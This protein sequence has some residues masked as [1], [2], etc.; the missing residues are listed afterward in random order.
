METNLDRWRFFHKDCESPDSYINWAF[1][2]MVSAC[3]QRRV[4]Y[5][6][7]ID[8]L[9][10]N[11]FVVLV[12]KPATGKGRVI[13]PVIQVLK[14]FKLTPNSTKEDDLVIP[15]GGDSITVE[16]LTQILAA[17]SRSIVKKE[18]GADGK[19]IV[20]RYIH[21]SMVFLLEELASL[22]RKNQ[23]DLVAFLTQA[24]DAGD[25]TRQT[26][27]QGCDFIKNVCLNILAGT[28]P[29]FIINC[30]SSNLIS[31][32]FASRVIFIYEE[33]P[34][35]RVFDIEYT[36]EQLEARKH[37]MEHLKKLTSLYGRVLF[38]QEAKEFLEDWYENRM[39]K[40]RKNR[41]PVLD[42]YYGRKKVHVIKLSIAMHFAD[43]VEMTVQIPSVKKALEALELI[44]PKMHLALKVSGKET[45]NPLA[46]I[47]DSIVN[48]LKHHKTVYIE[49][50]MLTFR[51]RK[52]DLLEI[53][54]NLRTLQ[55]VEV[56]TVDG[57]TKLAYKEQQQQP[58]KDSI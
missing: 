21:S 58:T 41:A 5:G 45:N 40:E 20:K 25:Y 15:I 39:D 1:Y 48:Y 28:Q 55:L 43:S 49:E 7:D 18:T 38:S 47:Q 44:E 14:S 23:D 4:W 36:P 50:I 26:K 31:L 22:F 32:G 8:P 56:S 11:M 30:F 57:R 42:G 6:P 9:F 24:W 10:P 3:L 19:E 33:E 51:L 17:A 52:A 37:V 35:K 46:D 54:D 13:K 12:G 27:N 29:E 53:I 16:K 2:T 34:R